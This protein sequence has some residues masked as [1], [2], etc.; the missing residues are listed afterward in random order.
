MKHYPPS[1]NKGILKTAVGFSGGKINDASFSNARSGTTDPAEAVR[2]EFD[3]N[4]VS[5]AELVGEHTIALVARPS[6]SERN[7]SLNVC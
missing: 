5:Y 6:D 7:R 4:T 1:Q 2:I 3:P